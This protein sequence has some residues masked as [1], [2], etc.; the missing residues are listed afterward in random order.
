[1]RVLPS[2]RWAVASAMMRYDYQC[3]GS[4]DFAARSIE[5][6]VLDKVDQMLREIIWLGT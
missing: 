4:G 1:M 2:E 6:V 5:C 3:R